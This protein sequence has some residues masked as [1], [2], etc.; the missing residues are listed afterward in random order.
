MTRL[1]ISGTRRRPGVHDSPMAVTQMPPSSTENQTEPQLDRLPGRYDARAPHE[2]LEVIDELEGSRMSARVRE[3]MWISLILHLIV[4]WWIFYGPKLKFLQRATVVNPMEAIPQ[5]KK[6]ETVYLNMPPDLIKKP[7]PRTNIISD[8]NHTAQTKNPSNKQLTLDQLLAQRRAGRPSPPPT[9]RQQA[10]QQQPTRPQPPVR[11]QQQQPQQQPHPA[12][13]QQAHATQPTPPEQHR[14]EQALPS[15]PSATASATSREQRP[16][17]ASKAQPQIAQSEPNLS[18]GQLIRR[19]ERTARSN[20]QNGDNGLGAPI[21]HAGMQS[22]VEVLSD[23]RG[24][25]FGPYLRQVIQ[26]TQASWDLLIPEAARPPLLKKGRVAIQFLI[27]P[28]GSIKQMQLVLPSG[29]VSLDRAAWGGITGAGPFQPLPKQFKGPYL[30][31]RFY[32]LY[33]EQ[34]GQYEPQ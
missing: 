3:A 29:D 31:L 21:S 26:A 20:G 32:F 16:Q 10:R 17:R 23:T 34:T 19:A 30:A 8:Q 4:F 14:P 9:P 28:D 7:P 33:N 1:R 27:M 24:V 25:D 15:A 6:P 18:V 13:P 22:G 11:P 2:L 12:Q 5:Q